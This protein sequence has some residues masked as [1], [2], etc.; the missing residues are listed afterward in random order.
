MNPGG[1]NN[2]NGTF[3]TGTGRVMLPG[4]QTATAGN[5]CVLFLFSG[6]GL[7]TPTK[8]GI[9]VFGTFL[10]GFFNEV[11]LWSRKY[12]AHRLR[13]KPK[14]Y[15]S[16]LSFVYGVQMVLAYWMMLLVMTYEAVIFSALVIGLATGHLV[17]NI[18]IYKHEEDNEKKPLLGSGTPCCGGAAIDD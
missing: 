5:A 2:N 9:A 15:R 8:Y 16:L 14:A 3:C 11:L 7:D 6:W 4:F 10:M 13:G 12:L 1:N 18:W 17:F